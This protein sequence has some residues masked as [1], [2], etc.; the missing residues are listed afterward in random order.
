MGI[1]GAWA[2]LLSRQKHLPVARRRLAS[3]GLIVLIQTAFDFWT[4]QVS[5]AAH[6]SGLVTGGVIGLL[7]APKAE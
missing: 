6:L 7:L 2:G 1:V 3:I 4:P 5:M